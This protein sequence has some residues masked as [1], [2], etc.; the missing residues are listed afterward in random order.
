[1]TLN[2]VLN[3][4]EP[5]VQQLS[6]QISA[7]T[8]S[9]VSVSGAKCTS[10]GAGTPTPFGSVGP[11]PVTFTL[12]DGSTL[13]LAVGSLPVG[14]QV[15][16]LY[17]FIYQRGSPDSITNLQFCGAVTYGPGYCVGLNP[18]NQYVFSS[19]NGPMI[20]QFA[21]PV[22]GLNPGLSK[23]VTF[24]YLPPQVYGTPTSIYVPNSL[25]SQ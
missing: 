17:N 7:V 3:A 20:I 24:Q 6:A 14:L 10:I 2:D 18:D 21:G 11:F 23:Q 4:L 16:F 19:P 12:S 13:S 1:M 8:S 25:T 15:N 9:P 22:D 5:I